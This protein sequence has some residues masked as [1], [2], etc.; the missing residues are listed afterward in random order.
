MW[1]M[2]SLSDKFWYKIYISL[3]WKLCDTAHSKAHAS[4][5]KSC[6]NTV[7]LDV[8]WLLDT[9]SDKRTV[10]QNNVAVSLSPHGNRNS[11]WAKRIVIPMDAKHASVHTFICSKLWRWTTQLIGYWAIYIPVSYMW[12]AN[13]HASVS[14]SSCK[15]ASAG[16]VL[17]IS[18][19]LML[20]S[21]P[22]HVISNPLLQCHSNWRAVEDG[23]MKHQG[24]NSPSYLQWFLNFACLCK[25]PNECQ[26]LSDQEKNPWAKTVTDGQQIVPSLKLTWN[27]RIDNL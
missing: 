20:D 10:H 25:S 2:P 24:A 21:A 17:D 22:V 5:N 19:A 4:P 23:K 9:C 12:M 3:V 27:P 15:D 13:G 14:R 7:W 8:F 11:G 1:T 18:S 26:T 6:C 16:L